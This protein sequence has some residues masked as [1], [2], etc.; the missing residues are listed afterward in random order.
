M[1]KQMQARPSR[2]QDPYHIPSQNPHIVQAEYTR[3]YNWPVATTANPTNMPLLPLN[4]QN[5]NLQIPTQYQTHAT[6]HNPVP[7]TPQSPI[8]TGGQSFSTSP[9]SS[10]SDETLLA[11]RAKGLN[12]SEIQREFFPG[13]SPNACRK[14][15]ER[16][17]HKRQGA[18]EWNEDRLARLSQGYREMR[19]R[20]WIP[21]A[22]YMGE[23]ENWENVERKVRPVNINPLVRDSMLIMIKCL[24]RGLRSLLN[25]A[26][27]YSD[28]DGLGENLSNQENHD[29]SGI[30]LGNTPPDYHRM[31][32][33]DAV[34]GGMLHWDQILH[35]QDGHVV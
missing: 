22:Q 35:R 30:A 28:D 10:G 1:P 20:I 5:L 8:K 13:K 27:R 29:D 15:Y 31:T 34:N 12:W 6:H 4:T 2:R 11:L 7:P 3:Q 18:R 16:I 32:R 19:A 24:E 21:L 33:K 14:R 26:R 23:G 17:M 9:W 25:L